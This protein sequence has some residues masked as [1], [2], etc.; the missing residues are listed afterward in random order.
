MKREVVL[1]LIKI[2]NVIDI[3][4]DPIPYTHNIDQIE[5][6]SNKNINN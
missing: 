3:E 1:E 6:E 5:L 4:S 2:S